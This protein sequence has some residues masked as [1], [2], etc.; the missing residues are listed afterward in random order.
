MTH[1]SML[2]SL[3][4]LLSSNCADT[5][6][7][8]NT[9]K[10]NQEN[11]TS[12]TTSKVN[13]DTLQKAYFA[14]GC[15]WCVEAIFENVKGVE[16]V[17]SGYSGGKTQNPSYEQVSSG[18]LKHAEAVEVRYHPDQVDF[19]TLLEVFFASHDPTTPN[20]QGPD[21]GPQYR[22]IA[23]YQNNTEKQII[24]DYIKEL[25]KKEIYDK[26]IVTEVL[27]FVVF[28]PAE[29]Y[30]QDFEKRHPNHPYVKAVSI[31]R[32]LKFEEKLP[33]LLKKKH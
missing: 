18:T 11:M 15:F 17:I 21:R 4:L 13:T 8:N 29:D 19:K 2:F 22:S 26:P 28:Y 25:E 14:A 10:N 20:Q 27:P 33:G 5:S 31:P 32:L 30:H 1:I 16:E 24:E 7:K 23:F 3:L 6:V 9:M 12:A